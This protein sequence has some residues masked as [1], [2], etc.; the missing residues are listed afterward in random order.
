[1]I[2]IKGMEIADQHF[3]GDEVR[4]REA[5]MWEGQEG[6]GEFSTPSP[7]PISIHIHFILFSS[8][9]FKN[10]L[11]CISKIYS[12]LTSEGGESRSY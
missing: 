2:L 5:V 1:M 12:C 10:L 11:L 7:L 8:S 9:P 3:M 4:G 6:E